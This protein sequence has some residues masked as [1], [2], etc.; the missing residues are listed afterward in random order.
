MNDDW[1]PHSRLDAGE[2]ACGDLVMLIFNRMKTLE[3][4]QRLEVLAHDLAADA[5][6]PAWCRST[7][8]RLLAQ[9]T[10][11]LPKRFLIQKA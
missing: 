3:S 8:N 7:G 2:T 9:Q 11:S 6:I 1:T 10:G 4:G 5:D